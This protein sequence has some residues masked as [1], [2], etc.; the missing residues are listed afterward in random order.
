M[1]RRI[2]KTNLGCKVQF[3]YTGRKGKYN[4]IDLLK[5]GLHVFDIYACKYR[6]KRK[7]N[8]FLKPNTDKSVSKNQSAEKETNV[9]NSNNSNVLANSFK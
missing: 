4:P 1:E 9:K 5:S 2:S 8:Y 6:S 7:Q 3:L